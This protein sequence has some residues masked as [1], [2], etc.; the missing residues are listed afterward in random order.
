VAR[1]H[2]CTVAQHVATERALTIHLDNREII[3]VMTLD[4]QPEL[5]TL[6]WLL[7]HR[8][9]ENVNDVESILVKWETDSVGVF[10]KRKVEGIEEKLKLLLLAAVRGQCTAT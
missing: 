10:T 4:T 8:L 6:G 7:N 9:V 2:G 1:L 3:T 5:L